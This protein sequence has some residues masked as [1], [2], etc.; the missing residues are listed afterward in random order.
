MTSLVVVGWQG[1]GWKLS[2][3][4]RAWTF[5]KNDA[6]WT[7]TREKLLQHLCGIVFV[8][9]LAMGR[10][11]SS[12]SFNPICGSPGVIML[13]EV[14]K[15]KSFLMLLAS[16][17][18]ELN[19]RYVA[20]LLFKMIFEHHERMALSTKFKLEVRPNNWDRRQLHWKVWQKSC[21][22]EWRTRTDGQRW[23]VS[24]RRQICRPIRFLKK[25]LSINSSFLIN[26]FAYENLRKT[27]V[28][29]FCVSKVLQTSPT[30]ET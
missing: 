13:L 26:R 10:Q 19:S 9:L 5:S 29:L 1:G 11:S 14:C 22:P 16:S 8:L 7:G 4:F 2:K 12:S 30:T 27:C 25:K 17:C 23:T 15:W 3:N 24:G 18:S 21:R 28:A 6:R 20:L